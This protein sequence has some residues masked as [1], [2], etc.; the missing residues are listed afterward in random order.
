VLKRFSII[1]LI[2][3]LGLSVVGAASASGDGPTDPT[4]PVSGGM[5]GVVPPHDQVG[6]VSSFAFIPVTYHGGP[7]MHTNKT[8]TIYWNP[9]GYTMA[10]SYRSLINRYFVDVA[11]ASGLTSNVYYSDTQYYGPGAVHI[12]YS[13]TYGGTY[14]DTHAFPATNGCALVSGMTK[15]LSDPQLRTEISRVIALNGWVANASTQFFIFTPNHV[16]SCFGSSCSF[17][18]FCAYHS[19]YG[20]VI[21]ANQPYAYAVPSACG[22]NYATS[23]PPNGFAVDSTLS[24][25]SHEHKEAIT[26]PHLNAWYDSS[27]NE[28]SDKCAWTFGTITAGHNQL[29]HGH[30]YILQRSWSNYLSH[31]CVLTGK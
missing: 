5:G 4:A 11:A 17:T 18:S 27:G 14:N 13:S 16:R 10:S 3:V 12:L 22:I 21:Y 24:V 29:I 26:D 25:A 15:C 7:V 28:T 30:Y 31:G 9:T 8:Y 19:Y 1:L 2:V 23:T 6:L 20:N